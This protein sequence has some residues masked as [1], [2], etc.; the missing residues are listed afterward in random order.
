M[1]NLGEQIQIGHAHRA[2]DGTKLEPEEQPVVKQTA[3]EAAVD[4]GGAAVGALPL[5]ISEAMP[6]HAAIDMLARVC[7]NCVHFRRDLWIA[8]RKRLEAT[9][10]G[11][12]G[13]NVVRAEILSRDPDTL[14]SMINGD[15]F[16][17]VEAALNAFGVC[18]ALSA[19]VDD[20]IA[21]PPEA[22]CPGDHV[23]FQARSDRDVA[24]IKDHVL[25]TASRR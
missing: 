13:L 3:S 24:R 4:A 1:K 22:S 5:T 15:E 11:R 6:V 23:Y 21:G 10:D 9:R 12:D 8:E 19:V 14:P 2:D 18:V 16:H 25:H 20:M 17:D 7:G